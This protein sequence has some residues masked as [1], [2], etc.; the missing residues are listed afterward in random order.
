V[1]YGVKC[2]QPPPISGYNSTPIKAEKDNCKMFD[3]VDVVC[4]DLDDTLWPCRPVLERAEQVVYAWLSTHC[5]AVVAKYSSAGLVERRMGYMSKQLHLQHDMTSM[6]YNFF[7]QLFEEFGIR[8]AGLA[9]EALITFRSARNQV[10]PFDDVV[11]ALNKLQSKYVLT[12]YSNGNAQLEETGLMPFF[13]GAHLSE[14][15]GFAKP[16]RQAF[17]W[18]ASHYKTAPERILFVGDDP[19]NDIDGPR[20]AGLQVCWINRTS[21]SWESSSAAPVSVRNLLELA[22]F[23]A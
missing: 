19:G 13:A 15:T 5:P 10:Q 2:N 4:F 17:D 21:S 8:D 14:H 18:L 23:L 22:A 7:M 1:K 11:P 9:Q 6:R 20:D 16:K 12:S 3:P